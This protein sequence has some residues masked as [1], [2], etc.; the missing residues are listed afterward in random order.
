MSVA[1]EK[2]PVKQFV[3][4]TSLRAYGIRVNV[5]DVDGYSVRRATARLIPAGFKVRVIPERV[6]SKHREGLRGA[7]RPGGD[8]RSKGGI[9]T[10]FVSNGKPPAPDPSTSPKPGQT[11]PPGGPTRPPRTKPTKPPPRP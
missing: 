5:P 4:P 2:L 7:H 11:L 6:P 1:L 10:I 3:K 8:D 9:I